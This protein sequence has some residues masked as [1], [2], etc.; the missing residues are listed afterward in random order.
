VLLH[1][2]W[3]EQPLSYKSWAVQLHPDTLDEEFWEKRGVDI[4]DAPIDDY[5]AGLQ[6]RLQIGQPT[7]TGQ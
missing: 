4:L 3:G 1:R 7:P 6:G 5:V 2:I